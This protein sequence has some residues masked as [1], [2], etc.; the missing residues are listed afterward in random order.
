MAILPDRVDR[1]EFSRDAEAALRLMKGDTVKAFLDE[2]IQRRAGK[3]LKEF[4]ENSPVAVTDIEA[5]N[6]FTSI[7]VQLT[8]QCDV[9]GFY[10]AIPPKHE[11]SFGIK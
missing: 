1:T 7:V 6:K 11:I 9:M 3:E 5:Q 10:G 8:L 4:V 2:L